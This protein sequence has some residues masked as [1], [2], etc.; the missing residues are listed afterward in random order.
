MKTKQNLPCT[1]P[2]DGPLAGA[3]TV[4]AAVPA[5]SHQTPSLPPPPRTLTVTL[6]AAIVG[7]T[8]QNIYDYVHLGEI[9]STYIGCKPVILWRDF[10]AWIGNPEVAQA[11]WETYSERETAA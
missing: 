8:R 10:V 7:R 5:N 4:Q 2:N 11:L 3:S 6:A 1:K 9:K